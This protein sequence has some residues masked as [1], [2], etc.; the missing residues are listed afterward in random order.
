MFVDVGRPSHLPLTPRLPD[1]LF[2]VLLE[3]LLFFTR[4]QEY[5]ASGVAWFGDVFAGAF[6]HAEV[7]DF[8]AE[9]FRGF[10]FCWIDHGTI[11]SRR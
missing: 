5:P 8:L 1:L 3:L 4:G 11:V 9:F 2:Q 7:G 10:T 6:L